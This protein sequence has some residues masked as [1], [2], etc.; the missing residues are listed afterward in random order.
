MPMPAAAAEDDE[1]EYEDEEDDEPLASP[2]VPSKGNKG[3]RNKYPSLN[4]YFPMVFTFPRGVGRRGSSSSGADSIP[5]MI[6]AIANS[7]STAKG[8]VASSVARAYG[9][10]PTYVWTTDLSLLVLVLN[11]F[12]ISMRKRSKIY[13]I[14]PKFSTKLQKFW[15]Y[16]YILEK[17]W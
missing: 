5:G 11:Y 16:L 4:N 7:Y 8:G 10:A 6:T 17:Y 1:E 9:G 2:V 13:K 14:F 12:H 3:R 15:K